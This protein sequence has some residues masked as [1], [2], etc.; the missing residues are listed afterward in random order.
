[1]TTTVHEILSVERNS[2][3]N[4]QS[5][6][7]EKSTK[8]DSSLIDIPTTDNQPMPPIPSSKEE[9]SNFMPVCNQGEFF[10]EP[11]EIKQGITL[12]GVSPTVEIPEK[13]EPSLEE[14]K[15]AV[16]EKL[17]EGLPPMK[18]IQHHDTS[19]RHDFEDPFLQEE[20][21]Q[22]KNFQFFKFISPT[23]GIWTQRKHDPS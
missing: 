4:Q 5:S 7:E 10:V 23:I 1:L 9:K 21:A 22:D 19:I 18:D 11:K 16:H 15:E 8:K 6:I 17:T 12:E 2:Q 14:F 20:N 13:I 3:A